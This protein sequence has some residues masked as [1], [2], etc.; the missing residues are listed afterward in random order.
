MRDSDEIQFNRRVFKFALVVIFGL[1]LFLT[2]IQLTCRTPKDSAVIIQESKTLSAH[3]TLCMSL[4]RPHDFELRY[5]MVGGNSK[6]TAIT[7]TFASRHPFNDV[8]NFFS[9]ELAAKGWILTDLY[10]EEM[11]PLEKHLTYQKGQYEITIGHQ[12]AGSSDSLAEYTV[13][14][15]KNSP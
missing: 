15:A 13:N 7:Y 10:L 11:T 9:Q 4:P 3:D 6:R 5:K 14:C 1:A 8:R 2:V 12:S